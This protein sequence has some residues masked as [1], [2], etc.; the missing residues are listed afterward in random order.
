MPEKHCGGP[1]GAAP[2]LRRALPS[3]TP[4]NVHVLMREILFL[5]KLQFRECV[6]TRCGRI[7]RKLNFH[8][9]KKIFNLSPTI[10]H[11]VPIA[12]EQTVTRRPRIAPWIRN[13][14]VTQTTYINSLCVTLVSIS[15]FS[16]VL[17]SPAASFLQKS[18]NVLPGFT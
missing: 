11:G 1:R 13:P 9:A 14:T 5:W 18:Q 8:P 16:N 12:T 4:E 6:I 17:N 2:R 15:Q 3:V 7:N 10:P